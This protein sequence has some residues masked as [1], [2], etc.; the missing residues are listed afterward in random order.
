MENKENNGGQDCVLGSEM[1]KLL[2][3]K[4]DYEKLKEFVNREKGSANSE[5]T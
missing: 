4:D 5:K 2:L 1:L 3:E